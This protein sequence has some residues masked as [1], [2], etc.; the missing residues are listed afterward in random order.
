[1]ERR[2]FLALAPVGAVSLPMLLAPKPAMAVPVPETIP[3]TVENPS[4]LTPMNGVACQEPGEVA[5][6]FLGDDMPPELEQALE[7]ALDSLE[8]E[9]RSPDWERMYKEMWENYHGKPYRLQQP[10]HYRDSVEV[11]TIWQQ[12]RAGVRSVIDESWTG[13]DKYCRV[14]DYEPSTKSYVTYSCG[15]EGIPV[16]VSPSYGYFENWDA[17]FCGLEWMKYDYRSVLPVLSAGGVYRSQLACLPFPGALRRNGYVIHGKVLLMEH[18]A[19]ADS[20]KIERIIEVLPST[21]V[22]AIPDRKVDAR[23]GMPLLATQTTDKRFR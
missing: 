23:L 22:D 4:T 9:S 5:Y 6:D 14:Y 13:P 19:Q 11:S 8:R 2:R 7:R 17:L 10:P 3:A 12:M 20:K 1:M 15:V 16:I 18:K 21:I